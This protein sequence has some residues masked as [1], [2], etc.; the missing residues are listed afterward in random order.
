[1]SPEPSE[2]ATGSRAVR[3]NRPLLVAGPLIALGAATLL[4]LGAIESGP[5]AAIGILG[6]GLIA[7][8]GVSGRRRG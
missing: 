5:A 6:I 1:M 8:A 2:S 3:V 4:V 7:A